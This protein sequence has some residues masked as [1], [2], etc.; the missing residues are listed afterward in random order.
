[1]RNSRKDYYAASSRG[2]RDAM[3]QTWT[4]FHKQWFGNGDIVPVTVESLEKVSCL[5]KLGPYKSFK[6]YLSRIK[7]VHTES[8]YPWTQRLHNVA[9]RCMRSVLRGVGGPTRS[10]A[11]DLDRVV[12]HLLANDVA[13]GDD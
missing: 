7:E 9:R 12:S 2:P 8:G 5:F 4:R 11:F 10:E 3:I 1:M 13:S 6:N